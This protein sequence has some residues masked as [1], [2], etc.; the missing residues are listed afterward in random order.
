V[1]GL[2]QPLFIEPTDKPKLSFFL[3]FIGEKGGRGDISIIII[4]YRIDFN[5]NGPT[6]AKILSNILYA[7][8]DDYI[9]VLCSNTTTCAT[10]CQLKPSYN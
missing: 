5:E 7:L 8:M 2:K 4:P 10:E 1:K 3:N 9:P 6:S